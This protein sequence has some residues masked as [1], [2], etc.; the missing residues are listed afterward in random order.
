MNAYFVHQLAVFGNLYG[1]VNM[2]L[3][4]LLANF[5]GALVSVQLLRGDLS[6]GVPMNFKEIYNGFLAMYQVCYMLDP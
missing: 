1:L 4:L 6:S 5:V 3:F 2:S